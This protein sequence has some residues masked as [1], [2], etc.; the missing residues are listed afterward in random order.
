MT[1]VHLLG[2]VW[3]AHVDD[4]TPARTRARRSHALGQHV[5]QVLADSCFAQ[6]H[7]DEAGTS[8]FTLQASTHKLTIT[9]LSK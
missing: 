5:R 1:D 2:N 6:V 7:V 9:N 3:R 8:D 4:D